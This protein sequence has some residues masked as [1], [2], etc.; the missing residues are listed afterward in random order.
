[1]TA[2]E[3]WHVLWN[4]LNYL[5][6]DLLLRLNDSESNTMYCLKAKGS[7]AQYWSDLLATINSCNVNILIFLQGKKCNSFNTTSYGFMEL[8]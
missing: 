5:P 2:D 8:I 6:A 1:M 3:Q 7:H 4:A